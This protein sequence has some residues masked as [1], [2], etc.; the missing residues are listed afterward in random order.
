[1]TTLET[2][3]D[4]DE[5]AAAPVEGPPTGRRRRPAPRANGFWRFVFPLLVVAAG[6]GV[7]LLWR[8]GTKS[9]L[10]ST[11]GR[12]TDLVT[13]PEEPGYEV[14]VDPTPT[15]LIVHHDQGELVGVT[16]MARTALDDGG[17]MVLLTRDLLV[18]A[19]ASDD[20]SPVLL[21]QAY[22]AGGIDGVQ[23]VVERL[24][25]V[26][27]LEVLEL[28]T[29]GLGGLMGLVEPLP[30]SLPGDLLV[31]G[32]DSVTVWLE[33]GLHD[34]SG[35]TA[36]Q[37]YAFLN[38][39][40]ADANRVQRQLDLWRSWFAEIG[41]A[42]DLVAATLP[43]E[44]GIAPYLRSLGAGTADIAEPPVTP[45]LFD[46]VG[47]PIPTLGEAGEQWMLD[48]GREMVPLPVSS[49][50]APRPT[51]RLL[52]GTG[53]PAGRAQAIPLVVD[54]G[55]AVTV[56]GNASSFD[57][58]DTTVAHHRPETAA[59]AQELAAELGATV[60]FDEDVDQPV[61]LT[62]TI[63]LDREAG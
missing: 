41:V 42:D 33:A 25:G 54:G 8:E 56:I 20:G 19:G 43:F 50:A 40:E 1:V 22:T 38:P 36:A 37:V 21:H 24:L 14:F 34:L 17:S 47:Q 61:D 2:P 31:E 3:T 46:P 13:D 63:G 51:V 6:V 9:V 53:D 5:G 18:P 11:D 15:L 4:E 26:G 28:D 52:D 23:G 35:E 44:D 39:G 60:V 58:A 49:A 29:E 55:A 16:A 30:V 10:D 57:V 62:I 48:R 59:I 12:V 32:D 27:F 7:F 45:L